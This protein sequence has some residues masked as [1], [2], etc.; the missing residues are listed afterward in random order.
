[1]KRILAII[2]TLSFL[3]AGCGT[4]T[5]SGSAA[6]VSAEDLFNTLSEKLQTVDLQS[7]DLVVKLLG[8]DPD[9]V[10]SCNAAFAKD[11]GPGMVIVLE[12]KD[13]DSA[14]KASERMNYYLTTLQN[15]A[16]QYAPADLE[17]LNKGYVYTKDNYAVLYVGE[18][19]EDVK[20]DLAKLLS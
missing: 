5:S 2:L 20:K 19:V 1:M 12:G 9:S 13:A 4:D 14:L 6:S 7:G 17:I 3:I 8:V 10:V 11:G 16:A 18:S 15:S